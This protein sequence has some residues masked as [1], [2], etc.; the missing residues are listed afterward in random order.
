MAKEQNGS[1]VHVNGIDLFS[2]TSVLG[3]FASAEIGLGFASHCIPSRGR[4]CPPRVPDRRIRNAEQ[5][6]DDQGVRR[7]F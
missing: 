2:L 5:A 4:D 3:H 7:S 6:P 1:T